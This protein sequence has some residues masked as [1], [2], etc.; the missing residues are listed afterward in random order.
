MTI[1]DTARLR[2]VPI[3]DEHLDGLHLMNSDPLVMRYL[4]GRAETRDE[5]MAMIGRVKQRWASWGFSW[6]AVLEKSS[7]DLIGAAGVQYL[8]FDPANPHEIG[9]RL[10]ADKWGQGFASE[11]ARRLAA[12]AFGDLGAPL[13]CS[14]CH[15][16]NAASAR[17]MQRL[18]MRY[19]G[20][21]TH[22]DMLTSRY[23]ITRDEWRA[24]QPA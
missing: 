14:V 10:R 24:A 13:L 19:K 18:G 1:L 4:I 8:G 12:F 5:T 23:E 11:A 3:T 15:P 17:V 6:C 16:E 2:L 20:D 7:G 22:Y 9:W 21:E